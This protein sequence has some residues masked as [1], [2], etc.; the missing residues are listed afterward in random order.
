MS[1]TTRV[2][3]K[4][5]S[6]FSRSWAGGPCALSSNRGSQSAFNGCAIRI[7]GGASHRQRL[8]STQVT[9][10]ETSSLLR[11]IRLSGEQSTA[12]HLEKRSLYVVSY[13][14]KLG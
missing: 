3:R 14:I 1:L 11:L 8:G 10:A 4:N 13:V 9:L 5:C 7:P 6:R 2:R 12:R